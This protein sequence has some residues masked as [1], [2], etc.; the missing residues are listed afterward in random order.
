MGFAVRVL[1]ETLRSIDSATFTG[2]Y[3]ALGTALTHNAVLAKF[4][5]NSNILITVSWNGVSDHDVIPAGSF[6]LYDITA[7][8]PDST[9]GFFIGKGTQFYVKAAAGVGLVY[10]T[11]L[12]GVE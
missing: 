10:L 3:Q 11:I 8:K 6:A 4:V 7:N 1:P 5:N 9:P 12:Y 2:A